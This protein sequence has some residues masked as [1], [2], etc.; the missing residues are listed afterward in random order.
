MLARGGFYVFV[1][2]GCMQCFV[3]RF[4][5]LVSVQSIVWKDLSPKRPVMCQVGY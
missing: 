3:F 4:W 2:F 5:L 1:I